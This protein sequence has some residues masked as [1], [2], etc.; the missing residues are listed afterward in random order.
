MSI[1]RLPPQDIDTE[2]ACIASI[3]LSR[4]ALYRVL[5]ILRTEDFYLDKHRIIFNA[6][7]ELERKGIP[8][9][10]TTLKQ[11]LSDR[12]LFEK[13]GGDS[14]LVSIYQSVS[15]SANAGF[16]AKR[17]KELSLRRSLIDVASE[18]VAKCYDTMRE[19]SEL[20]DEIE[21]S[22]FA[23]TE[24]RISSTYV[25][26]DDILEKTMQEVQRWHG[27]DQLVTGTPTGFKDL[28]EMLTGFHGSE[29]IILAARPGMG[30]T[31]LA[32]NMMNNIVRQEKD[33][34]VLFFSIEMPMSQLGLRLL[35]L[36]SE[37]DSHL[38]RSGKFGTDA[39]KKL[40]AA[41]EVLGKH[42]IYIDD[43]PSISIMEL[44]AKARRLAQQHEI[45][46]I[47]VDYLQL[48]SSVTRADRHLQIA[49]ISRSLK[50]LSRELDV[51]VLALSQLSRAVEQRSDRRPTLADLRESGSIEQ[52]ADVVMFIFNEDKTNKDSEKKG[53]VELIIAKQRNG[54][55]GSIMLKFFDRITKFGDCEPNREHEPVSG[56]YEH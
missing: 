35:C 19:T 37:V 33:K 50:Q 52:D 31:A 25:P 41:R 17:I 46:L 26:L 16:Y 9:D 47:I 7:L 34:A 36:Q 18:A 4:E 28:D 55:V 48:I 12:N 11:S 10:L 13:V 8:V 56:F 14:G 53:I 27:A 2:T 49:E 40:F 42:K 29:L 51:P 45:S 24:R 23:V 43:T 22:V 54:P 5:E 15:T 3:L 30:K 32:L 39:L 20:V 1:D 44:R 21:Q 38:V 6:I